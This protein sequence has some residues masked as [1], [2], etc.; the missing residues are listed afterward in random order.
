MIGETLEITIVVSMVVLIAYPSAAAF[1]QAMQERRER[2]VRVMTVLE[3]AGIRPCRRK[4]AKAGSSLSI[5]S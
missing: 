2:R 1:R 5:E 3:Q 4:N